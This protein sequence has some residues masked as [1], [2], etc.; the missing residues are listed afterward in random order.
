MPD[1]IPFAALRYNLDHV[2]SLADVVAPPECD[3]DADSVDRL[4]KSH[5]ANVVR[6]IANRH[7][8]GDEEQERFERAGEFVVQ[9]ISEGV[10]RPDAT[11]A[12]FAFRQAVGSTANASGPCCRGWIVCTRIR[13]SLEL[14]SEVGGDAIS[15]AQFPLQWMRA[16]GLAS[17]PVV[18]TCSDPSGRVFE[19]LSDAF[20][21]AP[22][23]TVDYRGTTHSQVAV[24]DLKVVK[25]V[26]DAIDEQTLTL[27]SGRIQY[28]AA[29]EFRGELAKS[30][31]NL[32]DDHPA[33]F[34]LTMVVDAASVAGRD[35]A[36]GGPVFSSG[37]GGSL[38]M[39]FAGLVF[40]P[41]A[42]SFR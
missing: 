28:E 21:N 11:P 13:E 17:T 22:V 3:L 18:T 7:E 4:Y 2:S 1:T 25:S 39:R 10:L 33:N 38:P 5:P 36:G 19:P 32:L 40:Y 6:V 31:G 26:C 41:I 12:I 37:S 24:T 35:Q 16:T 14:P 20:E 29:R 9:W 15:S 8:P 27:V 30:E 34:V 42:A 23:R